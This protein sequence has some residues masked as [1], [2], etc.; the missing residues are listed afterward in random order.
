MIYFALR[1]Q[2]VR[3]ASRNFVRTGGLSGP[4]PA[5]MQHGCSSALI[6]DGA[7]TTC[8]PSPPPPGATRGSQDSRAVC[9]PSRQIATGG[10]RHQERSDPM[11]V[12]P[13]QGEMSREDNEPGRVRAR[14]RARRSEAALEESG[15]ANGGFGSFAQPELPRGSTLE[16]HQQGDGYPQIPSEAALGS[17]NSSPGF[18]DARRGTSNFARRGLQGCRALLGGSGNQSGV[19]SPPRYHRERHRSRET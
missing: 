3:L 11:E 17:L 5:R 14:V 6:G 1:Q 8:L 16:R 19:R 18:Q 2:G 12:E 15:R 4:R 13:I 9:P 7:H 10:H